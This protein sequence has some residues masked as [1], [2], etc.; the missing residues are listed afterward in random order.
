MFQAVWPETLTGKCRCFKA[1]KSLVQDS[2]QKQL[3]F[4]MAPAMKRPA[5]RKRIPEEFDMSLPRHTKESL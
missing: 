5:K 2:C 1:L 4:A 3:G